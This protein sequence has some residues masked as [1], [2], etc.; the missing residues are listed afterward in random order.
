MFVSWKK[1]DENAYIDKG[2]MH[3]EKIITSDLQGGVVDGMSVNLGNNNQ[4]NNKG[5]NKKGNKG[6]GVK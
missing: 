5:N 3:G 4:G 2:L 6:G 1:K